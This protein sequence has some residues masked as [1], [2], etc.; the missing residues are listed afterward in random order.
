MEKSFTTLNTYFTL[1]VLYG[2]LIG[3]CPFLINTAEARAFYTSTETRNIVFQKSGEETISGTVLAYLSKEPLTGV[4]IIIKG[5]VYGTTSDIEG[6]FALTASPDDTLVFSFIGYE[7]REVPLEGRTEINIELMEDIGMLGELEIVSTGYQ[8]LPR[9]RATGSFVQLDKEV[10]NRSV[11]TNII[12][13]MEGVTSGLIFNRNGPVGDELSIRGRSTLFANSQPM[14]VVD[15]FPYDGDISNINPNDVE[16]ITILKDA[17]AASIWG[18][19]AGNGVIVITTKKG[20]YNQAPAVSFNANVT[21]EERPDPFYQPQM[22][23]DDFID[24]EQMLFENG[25]YASTESSPANQPLSPVVELLIAQRDGEISGEEANAKI[26][27][28]S[29]QDIRHDYEEHLYRRS[30]NQQYAIDVRGGANHHRYLASMGYDRNLENLT[31]NQFERITLHARNTFSLL[32]DKLEFTAGVYYAQNKDKNNGINPGSLRMASGS[33]MYPYGR[34]VGDNGNSMSIIHDYRESFVRDAE[35]AGLLD[36]RYRPLEEIKLSD[37]TTRNT[38][39]RLN[40]QL[41]Y[42]ILPGLKAEVLYQYWSNKGETRNHRPLESYFTRDL[43]NTFTQVDAEGNLTQAIPEGGI[44]DLSNRES[45]SYNLR[46]QLRYEGSLGED[47]R[48]SALAGYE[49]RD[50][51]TET[52]DHRYYGYDDE[53]AISSYVDYAGFYSRYNYPLYSNQIP[54][55]DY[56]SS[57]TDR[58]VSYYANAAYTYD[59]RYTV[60]LSGRKDMSNLFG[61]DAN[62]RGVPLWSAGLSWN[63]SEEAFYGLGALPY[64][65]LRATYGFNGNIDKTVSAYTTARIAGTSFRTGLP[66]ARITNPPNPNLRWEQVK[67]L[68]LGLD[69]E[70]KEG[71]LGGSV[72]YY[73]KEGIDL[74][75][76]TPFPPSTGI[77]EFKGNTA[78]TRGEGVDVVLNS[79]NIKRSFQWRTN[80]LFSF[81][82]E[83]VTDYKSEESVNNYLTFGSGNLG[84]AVPFEGRPLFALYS[85]DWAGLDP[86]TGDPQGYLEGAVSKEYKEIIDATTPEMLV[87]HGPARP[88]SF[89]AFRN[90]FSWKGF[91]LSVNISYR[92]GY[93]FRRNSIRYASVLT[94]QGGHSDYGLRWRQPG[95]EALTQVPSMSESP[96]VNRDNL[97]TYS[98]ILV[99]KGDHVRLQDITLSYT[100]SKEKFP[101]LPFAS[102]ELYGYAGNLGIIWKASDAVQDPDYQTMPSLKRMSLGL[103]VNF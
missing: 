10:I 65:R 39:I 57:L 5:T 22:S 52:T 9:E 31:G 79:L 74:I 42:T 51:N 28:L 44:L 68:N 67:I 34:L 60:S 88:T 90:T 2:L 76:D 47:H 19:R 43:I 49:V 73:S 29:Q 41:S 6:N 8:Q 3:V 83:K 30:I 63:L 11:S 37:N 55:M 23:V 18:A 38:D 89:G 98:E 50:L 21:V 71:I 46:G 40:G 95:D 26:Q 75:G 1:L 54:Y 7:V 48:I 70:L 24:V 80:F 32:D 20:A 35:Q 91:S 66:Y 36:W 85:Y 53:L 14:I 4:N 102:M 87:Y 92:M 97:Y 13:R 69:F 78:N 84:M 59:N 82:K 100:L 103:R 56:L 72:E 27:A 81:I 15:N 99:E 25:Y 86:A 77:T 58:F 101:A 45:S 33:P 64:L 93:Y 17:A 12:D 61:V 94:A 96:D 62:Q 16:S